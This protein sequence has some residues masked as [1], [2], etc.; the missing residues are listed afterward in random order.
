MI[1]TI[2][3]FNKKEAVKAMN[4]LVEHRGFEIIKPLQQVKTNLVKHENYNYRYSRYQSLE[5][6]DETC[7]FVQLKAPDRREA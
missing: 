2:R 6:S 1:T 7:W 4:W 3:R 5:L